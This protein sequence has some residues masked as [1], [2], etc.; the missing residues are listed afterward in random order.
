[1]HAFA[2]IL[3]SESPGSEEDRLSMP[4]RAGSAVDRAHRENEARYHRMLDD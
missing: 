2:S 4:Q 1:V 3:G